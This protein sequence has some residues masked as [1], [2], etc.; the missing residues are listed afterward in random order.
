[1]QSNAAVSPVAPAVAAG[2]PAPFFP[3]FR[4]VCFPSV[5]DAGT[6]FVALV[7]ASMSPEAVKNHADAAINAANAED[8]AACDGTG[9]GGCLD[10][11]CVEDSI[12]RRLA[13]VGFLFPDEGAGQLV[14][15]ACWDQVAG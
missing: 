4:V 1:M 6:D 9:D 13:L 15:T 2:T 8:A 3:P 14:T 5:D 12:K 11:L 10:G 7:P